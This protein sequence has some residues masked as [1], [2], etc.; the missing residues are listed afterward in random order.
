MGA[1]N[2]V[3]DGTIIEKKVAVLSFRIGNYDAQYAYVATRFRGLVQTSWA[4][5]GSKFDAYVALFEVRLTSDKSIYL[6]YFS[7]R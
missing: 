3:V 7:F 2:P 1:G 5:K 6:S 4:S